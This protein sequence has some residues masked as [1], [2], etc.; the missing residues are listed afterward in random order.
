MSSS[1]A[2][3]WSAGW[4]LPAVALAL[5]VVLSLL[6]AVVDPAERGRVKAGIVFAGAYLVMQLAF[7]LLHRP[8]DGLLRAPSM[9]PEL[10]PQFEAL[11]RRLHERLHPLRA[12]LSRVL[13]HGDA[14]GQNNFILQEADGRHQAAFFDFDEAGPGY[15]LIQIPAG[16]ELMELRD[17]DTA[18]CDYGGSDPPP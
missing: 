10:R 9:T 8:L 13:C 12:R 5:L 15:V 1:V 7:Y 16:P 18:R 4:S 17:L 6:R 11:G 14:H 3:E 2:Q